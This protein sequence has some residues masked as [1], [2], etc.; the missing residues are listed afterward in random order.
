MREAL[1]L[2][3]FVVR[4]RAALIGGGER[5]GFAADLRDGLIRTTG[6]HRTQ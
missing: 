1:L 5:G 4:C 6:S 2:L 3:L